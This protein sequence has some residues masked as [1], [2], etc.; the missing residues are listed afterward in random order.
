MEADW[1]GN[2]RRRSDLEATRG[3]APPPPQGAKLDPRAT[4]KASSYADLDNA[5][6]A[7]DMI[8]PY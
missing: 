6:A 5:P 7:G 4:R 8:L 3:P 2:K 1:N